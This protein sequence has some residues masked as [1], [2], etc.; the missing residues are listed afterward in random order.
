M[1]PNRTAPATAGEPA[2]AI[3]HGLFIGTLSPLGPRQ[4]P[5]GID[6]QPAA[7]PVTFTRIGLHGDR[8]G[9]MRHHGGPE[10]AVH[11]Y[12]ADH[13]EKWRK[14]G[15]DAGPPAF[16]ENITTRGITEAD[17]CIGDIFRLGCALLQVSQGR[18]PCWRLNARFGRPD[19]AARVQNSGRTGWYYR[20]LEE[21]SAQAG[22]MLSLRERPQ[23]QWP[24]TRIIELLYARTMDI[25][26]LRELGG[27]PE[28]AP[29]WRELA[30]RRIA[31]RQVEDW[32]RRL[33]D[34]GA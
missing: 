11:H 3:V 19:M 21:G 14:E 18:Q 32:E 16:G 26:D 29:S 27:L 5:S 28:L 15:I 31:T 34:T 24:L 12:P 20:V 13:Y 33:H 30:A 8:Q 10:K 7:G 23:P 17:I 4:V 1:L 9:D 25:E 6:K 22:E 2:P